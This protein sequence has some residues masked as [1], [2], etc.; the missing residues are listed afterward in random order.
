MESL[1][2]L[3]KRVGLELMFDWL[4]PKGEPSD[5][6]LSRSRSFKMA[7]SPRDMLYVL[8]PWLSRGR[9]LTAILGVDEVNVDDTLSASEGCFTVELV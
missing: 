7:A 3:G 1:T 8:V 6:V 2:R 4:K 5:G 9:L